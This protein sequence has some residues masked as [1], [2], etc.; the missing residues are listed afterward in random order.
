MRDSPGP[1][2]SELTKTVGSNKATDIMYESKLIST[3]LGLS[4]MLMLY[5]YVYFVAVDLTSANEDYLG[6]IPISDTFF[7]WGTFTDNKEDTD[8]KENSDDTEKYSNP[9]C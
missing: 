1:R 2:G 6:E 7:Q 9:I 3:F 5:A 8:N 4:S